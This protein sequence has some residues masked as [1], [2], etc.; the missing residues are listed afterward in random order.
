M[1]KIIITM[2]CMVM[3]MLHVNASTIKGYYPRIIINV[4]I[5]QQEPQGCALASMASIEAYFYGEES[6]DYSTSKVYAQIK[7]QNLG[8][9]LA[10]WYRVGY[11]VK[12]VD[13]QQAYLEGLY[14]QLASGYPVIVFRN[15]PHYSICYGYQGDPNN[16]QMEGFL[17]ADVAK[18]VTQYVDLKTWIGKNKPTYDSGYEY[19]VRKQGLKD[20]TMLCND[21][22]FAINHPSKMDEV[23]TG[24]FVY[25]NI[26]SKN[27]INK[28]DVRVYDRNQKTIFEVHKKCATNNYDVSLLDND[29][30]FRSMVPGFYTYEIT[31]TDNQGKISTYAYQFAKVEEVHHFVNAYSQLHDLQVNQWYYDIVNQAYELNLMSGVAKNRFDPDGKMS[32][33]MVACVLFR[34]EGIEQYRYRYV[35]WDVANHYYGSAT[36]WAFDQKVINGYPDGSFHPDEDVSREQLVVMIR[37]YAM[38]KGLETNIKADLTQFKDYQKI[39]DYAQSAFEWA[40]ANE[41][42]SGTN[43]GLLEPNAKAT[44]AQAAKILVQFTKLLNQN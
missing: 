5:I 13:T 14:E 41:L 3:M 34:I 19:V 42:I 39:S 11:E 43:D 12:N 17:V 22:T 10:Y 32:R 20:A 26:V 7:R 1:K 6:Q 31:I 8:G 37:N 30:A 35:F 9:I 25:G 29:L 2:L 36:T 24:V 33:A 44:R 4:P 27:T 28:V 23:G 21:V 38:Y 16:L 15:S 40:Y 18:G